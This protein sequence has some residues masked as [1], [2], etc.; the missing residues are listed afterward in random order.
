MNTI[1][2]INRDVN[3]IKK[4]YNRLV[5]SISKEYGKVEASSLKIA[6]ALYEIYHGEMYEIDGY[7]NIY[8]FGME[9]FN[10]SRGTTNNFI[11][12]IKKFG[13]RGE[14]GEVICGKES[15]L[16]EEYEKFTF[17]KLCLLVSVPDE[18]LPEFYSTMT[19]REIR[20]KKEEISKRLKC[21]NEHN[22]INVDDEV[23]GT[24]LKED[25]QEQVQNEEDISSADVG[26]KYEPCRSFRTFDEMIEYLAD[27]GLLKKLKTEID[28]RMAFNDDGTVGFITIGTCIS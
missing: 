10:L 6:F 3:I 8:D 14:D 17:S 18:Y 4:E 7:K 11:N 24:S 19:A 12:I 15:G 26:V 25:E 27:P 28:E 1:A 23:I 5:G 9:R 2:E 22:L 13:L 20:E 21:E 16:F